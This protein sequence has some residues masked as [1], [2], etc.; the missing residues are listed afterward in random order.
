MYL[1]V[2]ETN[3]L[4]NATRFCS[5]LVCTWISMAILFKKTEVKL[6]LLTNPDML[7]MVEKIIKGGIRH[8]IHRYAKAN[9]KYMKI[10]GKIKERS[11][12]QYLDANNSYGWAMSQNCP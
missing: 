5:F 2:L 8:A 3:V 4:K 1:R 10:Y 9:I 11:Y 12:V 6:E 7:L